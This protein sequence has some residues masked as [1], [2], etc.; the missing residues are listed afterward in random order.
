MTIDIIKSIETQDAAGL[1]DNVAN[2]LNSKAFAK[3]ED[4]KRDIAS[5]LLDSQEEDK[6][7]D[8]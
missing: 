6:N 2:A 1:K 8:V 3:L 5:S 4:M 7:E